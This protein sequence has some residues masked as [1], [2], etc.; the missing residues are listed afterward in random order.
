LQPWWGCEEVTV[1]PTT[2]AA[3]LRYL[4]ADEVDKSDINFSKL[5][6]RSPDDSKI[7]DVDGFIVDAE[8]G[9]V[10]YTVVDSGGWFTSRRLLLPVGHATVD[11]AERALRVDVSKDTLS[12]YPEFDA[13]RFQAF[14]DDD[15]RGFERRMAEACCPDEPI[16]DV[17][18]P[19]WH[20]ETRRHYQQPEWWR[21]QPANRERF[22]PVATVA[23]GVS[24]GVREAYDRELVT[25]RA[26]EDDRSHRQDDDERRA[27]DVSPH[28]DG[29]AQPGDVLGLETGGER[30]SIG[31]TSEDEDK[32]RRS[33]ETAARD[34]DEDEPRRSER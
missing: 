10:Y 12:Q 26:W 1:A 17:S 19:A 22:R 24:P 25:A 11:R 6:V 15:L 18:V 7:G 23:S 33:A 34:A 30:T 31:D 20:F 13:S 9:R 27:S 5:D 3:R 4:P 14:S 21:D 8:S 16:E 2:Y 28:L 29:R 32:R